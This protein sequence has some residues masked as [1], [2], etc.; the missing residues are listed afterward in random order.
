M[1]IQ[2]S[3]DLH[4]RIFLIIGWLENLER[5]LFLLASVGNREANIGQVASPEYGSF[6]LLTAQRQPYPDGKHRRLPH[7][8]PSKCGWELANTRRSGPSC[9]AQM[10]ETMNPCQWI[11]IITFGILGLTAITKKGRSRL[12]FFFGNYILDYLGERK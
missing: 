5:S 12:V 11:L 1:D 8:A 9:G 2:G 6:S 7:G 3:K 4:T 10:W